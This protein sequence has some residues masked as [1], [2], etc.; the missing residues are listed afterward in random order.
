[1]VL[2]AQVSLN[3]RYKHAEEHLTLLDG[4]AVLFSHV[5]SALMRL[6][7]QGSSL[8][9]C[10]CPSPRWLPASPHAEDRT[11]ISPGLQQALKLAESSACRYL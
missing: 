4:L 7:G 9:S 6:Y 10:L 5:V 1:M 3:W 11:E 2:A 8:C